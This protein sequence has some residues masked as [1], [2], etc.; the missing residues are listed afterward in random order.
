MVNEGVVLYV[1]IPFGYSLF[2]YAFQPLFPS[3]A[4]GATGVRLSTPTHPSDLCLTSSLVLLSSD[5]SLTLP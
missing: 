5:S 2:T 3:G 1:H 4:S